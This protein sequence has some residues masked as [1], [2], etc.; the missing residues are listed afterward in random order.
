[1]L[2]KYLEVAEAEDK[3]SFV[4]RLGS[5]RYMD[6]DLTIAEALKTVREFLAVKKAVVLS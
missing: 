6:M 4:G 1:M 3:V 5:Y 2:E